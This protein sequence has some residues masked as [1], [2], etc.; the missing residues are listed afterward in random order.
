MFRTTEDFLIFW[1]AH[2][3][4]TERL[5][6]Q[7]TDES[8]SKSV[9]QD[10][11]TLG[12]L[13]WHIVITIPEMMREA[14]MP[15]NDPPGTGNVPHQA[16]QLGEQYRA[17]AGQLASHVRSHLTDADLRKEVRMYGETWTVGKALF[18]LAAHEIHHR[19]Q[20]TV[21][22][23]Q[24]GLKVPG[25]YGPALEEWSAMGMPAPAI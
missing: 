16:D 10:G 5:L 22:M 20:L 7:L 19:G 6:E 2:T 4:D 9:S 17:M 3:H 21:L 14:G 24:A 13:A 8:L 11:R 18:A 25:L 1:E 12:R 15:A 23:R